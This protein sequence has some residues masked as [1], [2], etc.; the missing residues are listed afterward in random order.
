MDIAEG[1][2]DVAIFEDA[3]ESLFYW[4]DV[5]KAFPA[6]S[7]HLGLSLLCPSF[8]KYFLEVVWHRGFYSE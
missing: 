7:L 3:I 8:L 6:K 1:T 4:S 5:C 2:C